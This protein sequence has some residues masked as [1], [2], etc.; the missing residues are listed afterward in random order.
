M[1]SRSVSPLPVLVAAVI[2]LLTERPRSMEELVEGMVSEGLRL[3]RE[4]VEFVEDLF[5]EADELHKVARLV[6]DERLFWPTAVLS[7]AVFT[8]VVSEREIVHDLLLASPDLLPLQ[9]MIISSDRE[10]VPVADGSELYTAMVGIDDD[11][12]AQRGVPVSVVK[13]DAWL[14]APGWFARAGIAAGDTVVVDMVEGLVRISRVEVAPFDELRAARTRSLV[15]GLAMDTDSAGAHEIDVLVAS[16]IEANTMSFTEPLPPLSELLEHGG[17][18]IQGDYLCPP[19]VD[20]RA[21]RNA[22]RVQRIVT[23]H[24]LAEDEA[25]TVIVLSDLVTQTRTLQHALLGG[26]G[27]P[28]G[29]VDTLIRAVNSDGPGPLA[30]SR[31]S[32]RP[33]VR[34]ALD[35]L[36]V[37]EVAEAAAVEVLGLQ[38]VDASALE[39]TAELLEPM[40][41][42]QARPAV[43]WLRAKA[44]ERAGHVLEAEQSLEAAY[45]LDPQWAPVLQDLARWASDRGDVERGVSL[46]HRAGVEADDRLLRLLES[47]RPPDRS[48]LARNDPCWCGSGRRYKA[49]HRGRERLDLPARTKW[50]YSKAL[51]HLVDGP[52]RNLHL[53]VAQAWADGGDQRRLVE[54]LG[55]DM[56]IDLT[57]FEGGVFDDFL[58]IR[59]VL[60]PD[61][62]RL[63]AEQWLLVQ[64]SVHEVE[65]VRRDHGFTARDIRTGDR[66]EVS[67]R[68]ATHQLKVGDLLLMRL[69]PTGRDTVIFG[70]IESVD[71][72]RRD[73]LVALLDSEP[74][75]VDLAEFIAGMHAPPT[76][77][78]ADGAEMVICEA[79]LRLPDPD[80][81]AAWLDGRLVR[82]DDDAMT[83]TWHELVDAPGGSSIRASV[84]VE[85]DE[86]TLFTMSEER[87]DALLDALLEARPEV[88]IL[89]QQR[90]TADDLAD[91]GSVSSRAGSR[92][93]S[94]ID[95]NDADPELAAALQDYIRGYEQ[96]W[97]DESI[98]AL[99]GVTPREAAADPTRRD[100]LVRLL[101]SF[102]AD[103]GSPGQMS[104]TRLRADLGLV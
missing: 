77:L 91:S 78:N 8:H 94:M 14:L 69:V 100:D 61:D 47:N 42:R 63:L 37:P 74:D 73:S 13:S 38:L 35:R 20:L 67:E 44:Q 95:P 72:A 16:A 82:H 17:F 101:D 55:E 52:G 9:L 93:S 66:H 75:P 79:R 25:Q 30:A 54:A 40:V 23:F 84:T 70:G 7:G 51:M 26:D 4:P 56:V 18:T 48:D 31:P 60:L 57:L 50:L 15:H 65:S 62:E 97:L 89:E 85:A 19:G 11:L 103:D 21:R 81:V 59:G 102:P 34:S 32:G 33:T 12:L 36:A 76:V 64:R 92:A 2:R 99:G 53:V 29:L 83:R 43:R 96:R 87:F 24:G 5:D 39:L 68:L 10:A 80:A 90:R 41:S 46:L 86:L 104:A 6:S 49:C 3:G 58:A 27:V 22:A 88:E 45:S 71:L 1:T 28:H 98:P